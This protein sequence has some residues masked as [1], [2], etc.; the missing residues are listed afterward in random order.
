MHQFVLHAW[1]V[2]WHVGGQDQQAVILA[3]PQGMDDGGH[4]AQDAA[5]ALELFDAGPVGVEPVKEFG[6]NGIGTA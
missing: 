5:R 3:F 4:Q 1:R 6:M 2:H